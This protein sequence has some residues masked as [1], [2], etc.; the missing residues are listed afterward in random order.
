[1]GMS[2]CSHA[3]AGCESPMMETK[4]NAL[5]GQLN[6][7]TKFA[8]LDNVDMYFPFARRGIGQQ[9]MRHVSLALLK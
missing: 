6:A 2:V 4:N 5:R 7:F 1:M 3:N 8:H 9:R